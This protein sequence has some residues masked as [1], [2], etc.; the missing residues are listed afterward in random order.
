M[1]AYILRRLLWMV[2][3]FFG[4]L[5]INFGVLRLQGLSLSD[6]MGGSVGS[7]GGADVGT[8][9]ADKMGGAIENY[10]AKFRRTGNDLP[11][12][13]NFRGFSGKATA[14]AMLR[15]AERHS[16]DPGEAGRCFR[17]EKRLWLM[18]P[19]LV[20]PLGEVMQDDSLASLHGPAS[21]ALSLCAYVTPDEVDPADAARQNA[22]KNRNDDLKRLRIRYSNDPGTGYATTDPDAAAKRAE[23]LAILARDRAEF[24][25]EGSRKWTALLGEAG[26]TVFIE[27][28]ATGRLTSES[29]KVPVFSLIADRWYITF[30]LNLTSIVIAW[31]V[32]VPLGIGSARRAGTATDT[33][34]SQILF[35]L[36]SLPGF[37]V[38]TVLLHHF[39][40]SSAGGH[41]GWFPNRGISSPDSQWMDTPHYLLDLAWHAALPLVVLTYG[42]FTGLSRYMRANVQEQ[43]RADYVR[44]ARAKGCSEDQVI[45]GHA[46]RNSLVTMITLGSGLLADLFG[47]A[48]IVEMVF[49]IPGLGSLLVDAAQ[50]SDAPLVMASTVIQVALL[51]VGILVADVL[52]AVADPRLRARYG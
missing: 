33:V 35:L 37:F 20:E 49:S 4:I 29:R 32:A 24:S 28:L 10:L 17:A 21:M 50:Q 11:A 46:A 43:M 34:T 52:Y 47:G 15:D 42:S 22:V 19:L 45:Y 51:L 27:R 36:W 40:T 8:L 12:L 25:H 23:L 7:K 31:V 38:A 6:E 9:R 13:I 44:T 2:P 39:C 48:L 16:G 41:G 26:F 5:I 30:W 18:G 1:S 3:T 14:V